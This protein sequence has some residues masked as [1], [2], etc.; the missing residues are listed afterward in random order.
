MIAVALMVITGLLP[1]LGIGLLGWDTGTNIAMLAGI[2]VFMACIGGNGWRTGLA[3]CLPFAVLAGLADWAAPEPW[4]AAIVLAV[5]A[6]LRGYA[7]KVGQHNALM[8][9]VIALGFIVVSPASANSADSFTSA[10]YVALL[11]LA[12]GL[13]ATLVTFVLRHRLHAREHIGLDP[14]RVLAYSLSLAGLV[15]VATW[16]VVD[17]RLGH[18]GGWVILTIVVV[19]QPSLGAG[20]TKALSRAAGTILGISI[21]LVAGV[22]VSGI[23][24][25]Y[26][27]GTLFLIAS[28]LFMLQGRPYWL[29]VALLTPGIVLFDSAGS[30]VQAV[31]QERL[32]A[33]LVGVVATV[34]VMLALAPLGKYLTASST[35]STAR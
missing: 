12:C 2:A 16:F 31:A 21:A 24:L 17:L 6:F 7:A 18:A 29:F 4:L 10:I 32:G 9:V 34:L 14:I 5:A 19:F 33:T 3:I 13:W 35:V 25:A 1:S 20:F 8:M 28:F 27:V 30:T 23:W 22:L 11:S 26:L 15:G